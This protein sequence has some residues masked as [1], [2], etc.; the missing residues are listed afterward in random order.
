MVRVCSSPSSRL[1]AACTLRGFSSSAICSRAALAA[2][3]LRMTVCPLQGFSHCCLLTLS[4]VTDHILPLVPL[5]AL[6]QRILTKSV[7]HWF[8]NAFGAIGDHQQPLF[9]LQSPA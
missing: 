3:I 6:Q 2:G 5:A 4:E 1:L 9:K 8:V 7:L